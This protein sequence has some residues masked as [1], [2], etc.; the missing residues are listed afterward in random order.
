MTTPGNPARSRALK[1]QYP[2]MTKSGTTWCQVCQQVKKKEKKVTPTRPYAPRD[3]HRPGHHRLHETALLDGM[4][5]FGYT[6]W[7]LAV[8]RDSR[9]EEKT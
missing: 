4:N 9:E 5:V 6:L 1:H 3:T 2:Y 8:R 7:S